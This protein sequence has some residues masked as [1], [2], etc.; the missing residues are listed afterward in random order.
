MET[1]TYVDVL[2][3]KLTLGDALDS[4]VIKALSY[5]RMS[6]T[7]KAEGDHNNYFEEKFRDTVE[8]LSYVLGAAL[9][10]DTSYDVWSARRRE[11]ENFLGDAAD[12]PEIWSHTLRV[13]R[14]MVKV[15]QG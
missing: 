6:N 10:H 4:M 14:D 13:T 12:D 11:V 5:A 3:T 1:E 7:R 9:G 2:D 8:C 15:W